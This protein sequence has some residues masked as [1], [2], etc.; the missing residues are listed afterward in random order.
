VLLVVSLRGYQIEDAPEHRVMG[1][2]TPRLLEAVR[3]P[4][5][6]VGE[7]TYVEDCAGMAGVC[8]GERLP[9][10]LLI[11]RGMVA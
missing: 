6:I 7:T 3:I 4:Y 2:V 10:A 8:R 1:E 5:R 9:A 11:R